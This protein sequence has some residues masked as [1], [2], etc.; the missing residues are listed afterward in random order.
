AA[1]QSGSAPSAPDAAAAYAALVR[2]PSLTILSADL[3]PASAAAPAHCYV[4]GLLPAAIRYHVQ[5]PLPEA[6]NGRFLKWG[7]GGKDGDLEF[8]DHRLAQGY[9]VANSN[10]GHD[11]GAE[12]GSWFGFVNRQADI[13]FGYRA[14]HLTVNAAKNVIRAYYG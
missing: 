3:V 4:R 8:A 2:I 6:W 10:M 14:V 13:D 5:L 7:D 12:P 9:A 11:G 1:A